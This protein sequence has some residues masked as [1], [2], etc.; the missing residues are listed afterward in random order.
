M[1][2]SSSSIDQVHHRC[3]RGTAGLAQ[4]DLHAGEARMSKTPRTR[5]RPEKACCELGQLRLDPNRSENLRVAH[6]NDEGCARARPEI[7]NIMLC[8]RAH[9]QTQFFV[10]TGCPKRVPQKMKCEHRK[11]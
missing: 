5:F 9:Y 3:P 4:R 8:D 7:F 11:L 1:Q 2:L 6:P 10:N